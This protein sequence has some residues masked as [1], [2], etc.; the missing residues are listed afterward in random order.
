MSAH[1]FYGPKGVGVLYMRK[2]MKIHPLAHGGHHEN[3]RRA[4]TENVPGIVGLARALEIC[5]AEMDQTAKREAQLRNA[6]QRGIQERIDDVRINGHPTHRLPGSL[7][8]CFE[9][10]EGE[11]LILSLDLKGVAA[12]TGSACSS[13]SLEPSHVLKAMGVPIELAHGSARFTLGRANTEEDVDY[14]LEVL[15]QIVERLRS[16]SPLR[17]SKRGSD[18]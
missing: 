15:P 8:L 16:M 11:A 7:N 14:V 18:T 17:S 3:W 12:S 5:L 9:A 1:K 6:L 13:G 4:G 10:L 2:G